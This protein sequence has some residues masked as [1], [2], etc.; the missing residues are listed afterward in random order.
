MKVPLH[1]RERVIIKTREHS[2]VLRQPIV[3]FLLLTVVCTFLLGYLSRTDLS[4][5]L[6]E[7]A[8]LWVVV[9]LVLWAALTLIWCV[10]P[11]VRWLRSRIVLTTERILFRSSFTSGKLQSVG[12][13]TVRDLIAHTKKQNAMTRAGTLDIVLGHGYVRIAHV[14]SVPYFRS[15]AIDAITNLRNNQSPVQTEASKSE[16]MAP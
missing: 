10:T 2:K 16:G 1:E 11:W 9:T 13:Y 12:L 5:W 15:L 14:P 7:N 4:P 6:A 3:V 8:G